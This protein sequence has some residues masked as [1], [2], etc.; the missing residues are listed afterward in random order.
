MHGYYEK[1]L[2]QDP[3]IDRSISFLW[4]KDC[5]LTSEWENYFSAIQH[6][7]LPIKYL[8]YKWVLDK[9]N[10]PNYNNKY[11]LYMS[12]VEYIGHILAGCPQMS[13]RFYLPLRYDEVAK[14]FLYSDIEKYSPDKKI[15]LSNKLEYIYTEKPREYWWNVS[16]KTATKVPHN[17]PDLII[18]NY[19]TKVCMI[20][21]FSCLLD[22]N[23]TKKVSE[24]L[25]V[26]IP[27][28]RKLQIMHPGY[29]FEIAPIA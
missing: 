27:L 3:G 20:V 22:I 6:Q 26:Y 7:E 13:S 18:W 28:V 1:K 9:G 23:T 17:K 11:R 4:K 25:E 19:E 10:I 29:K 8:Q 14:T 21:K 5:Y 12:I 24:K 15:T 16:I 2:E